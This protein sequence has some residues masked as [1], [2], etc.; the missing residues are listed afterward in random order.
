M[1][2]LAAR[3]AE[4]RGEVIAVGEFDQGDVARQNRAQWRSRIPGK[5][6]RRDLAAFKLRD[7]KRTGD[8]KRLRLGRVGFKVEPEVI[9]K[10]SS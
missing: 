10:L 9:L 2:A 4:C 8:G 1:N 5:S 7:E 6:G 3:G